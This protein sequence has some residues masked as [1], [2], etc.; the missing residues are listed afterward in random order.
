MRTREEEKKKICFKKI[1]LIS[2]EIEE[3]VA[4]CWNRPIGATNTAGI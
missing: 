2:R 4:Q 3:V 1:W